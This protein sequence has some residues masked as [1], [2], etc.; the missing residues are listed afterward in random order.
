MTDLYTSG[1][2]LAPLKREG[3]II[4]PDDV[5]WECDLDQCQECRA[6]YDK[7]KHRYMKQEQRY[8]AAQA[9]RSKEE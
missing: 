3:D 2:G 7:W 4:N 9:A 5:T 1:F 8:A 6:K